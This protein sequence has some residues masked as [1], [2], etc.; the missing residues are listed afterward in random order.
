MLPGLRGQRL[1]AG[2]VDLPHN[3][4]IERIAAAKQYKKGG[5]IF[6]SGEAAK[7]LYR[8]VTGVRS[9]LFP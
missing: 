9:N 1:V 2:D 5:Q 6:S 7:H 8:V 4:L 3:A